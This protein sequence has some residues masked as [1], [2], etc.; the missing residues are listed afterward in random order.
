MIGLTKVT[1]PRWAQLSMIVILI[2]LSG[3]GEVTEQGWEPYVTAVLYTRNHQRPLMIDV[4]AAMRLGNDLAIKIN[5]G[6]TLDIMEIRCRLLPTTFGKGGW[7]KTRVF[8]VPP[9][10]KVALGNEMRILATIRKPQTTG[11]SCF[12]QKDILVTNWTPVASKE[13]KVTPSTR[14]WR[15]KSDWDYL[16]MEVQTRMPGSEL[17]KRRIYYYNHIRFIPNEI[18]KSLRR[19]NLNN[20][21]NTS[22]ERMKGFDTFGPCQQDGKPASY[23][24]QSELR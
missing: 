2:G 19:N 7:Y 8:E 21:F 20:I 23:G 16:S 4:L 6:D 15:L 12:D 3:C 13:W 10:P 5:E 9:V 14:S 17:I 22:L 11:Y 24:W 1:L 18:S